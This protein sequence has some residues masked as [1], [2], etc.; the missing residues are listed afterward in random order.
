M[1]EIV[2]IAMRKNLP[3]P[4]PRT[5]VFQYT[6]EIIGFMLMVS[7]AGSLRKGTVSEKWS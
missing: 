2:G 3:R 4:A 1:F 7:H 5:L 6:Q